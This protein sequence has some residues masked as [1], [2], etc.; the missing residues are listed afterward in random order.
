MN[1]PRFGFLELIAAVSSAAMAQTGN[2]MKFP[3]E[4]FYI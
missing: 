1:L 4:L 3:A 2:A